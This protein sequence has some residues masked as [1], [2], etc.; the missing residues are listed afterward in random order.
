M[1]IKRGFASVAFDELAWHEDLRQAARSESAKKLASGWNA[2][3]KQSMRS[4]PATR[5]RDGTSLP[6]CVKVYLPPP[7]GPLG[8]VFR[9][10]KGKDGRLHLD[11]LAFGVRHIYWRT[12]LISDIDGLVARAEAQT[13]MEVQSD[14]AKYL[15]IRVLG[16]V[17]QVVAE[18]VLAHVSAQASPPVLSHTTWKMKR[19]QNPNPQRLIELVG[20]F[21]RRWGDSLESAL[22]SSSEREALGSIR[23]QRNRIAHGEPTTISLVQV[24]GYFAE[25][26]SMLNRVAAPF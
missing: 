16:L 21:D 24:K 13:D 1:P 15:T 11:H 25:I 4:S 12:Q 7:G 5:M 23:S 22:T 9:L 14:Y 3:V 6:G 17:E 20:S 10:A 2:R 18:I 26:K 8:L 19:F